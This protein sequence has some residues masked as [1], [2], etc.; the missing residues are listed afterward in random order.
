MFSASKLLLSHSVVGASSDMLGVVP[1]LVIDG[2]VELSSPAL[3]ELLS[4]SR[5]DIRPAVGSD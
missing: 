4:G 3:E 2:K 5:L 1:E